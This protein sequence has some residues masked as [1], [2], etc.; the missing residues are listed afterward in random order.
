MARCTMSGL[1]FLERVG[2][3]HEWDLCSE[4][5]DAGPSRALGN[6]PVVIPVSLSEVRRHKTVED[7]AEE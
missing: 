3:R 6:V 4:S 5:V 1:L 2:K 7:T